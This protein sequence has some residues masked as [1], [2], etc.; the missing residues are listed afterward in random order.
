MYKHTF[1]TAVNGRDPN[2]NWD[3]ESMLAR[4]LALYDDPSR[5]PEQDPADDTAEEDR[6]V[7]LVSYDEDVTS[8]SGTVEIHMVP[9]HL[10]TPSEDQGKVDRWQDET[11]VYLARTN[12]SQPRRTTSRVPEGTRSSTKPPAELSCLPRPRAS[13]TREEA[14]KART[15]PRYAVSPALPSQA[16][17]GPTPSKHVKGR[18]TTRP[19]T[20]WKS[21][22]LEDFRPNYK[23]ATISKE[24]RRDAPQGDSSVSPKKIT[25]IPL[26]HPREPVPHNNSLAGR[27]PN[28][29]GV[30]A[31]CKPSISKHDTPHTRPSCI[32]QRDPS[33]VWNG[34]WYMPADEH[35][36]FLAWANNRKASIKFNNYDPPTPDTSAA[37]L[38][39]MGKLEA[40]CKS[41]KSS[42]F[43]ENS[44]L[45][46]A[47]L[48]NSGEPRYTENNLDS[49]VHQSKYS[50]P[51]QRDMGNECPYFNEDFLKSRTT[52]SSSGEP[53]YEENIRGSD[54]RESNFSSSIQHEMGNE[55]P[56]FEEYPSEPREPLSEARMLRHKESID[57]CRTRQSYY[58]NALQNDNTI[59]SSPHEEGSTDL[60]A[61][62]FSG[63]GSSNKDTITPSRVRKFQY[64][65]SQQD[66]HSM[67]NEPILHSEQLPPTKDIVADPSSRSRIS[68][69]RA[70]PIDLADRLFS[71]LISPKISPRLWI[72]SRFPS[73]KYFSDTAIGS[74]LVSVAELPGSEINKPDQS[75]PV[76]FPVF[77]AVEGLSPENTGIIPRLNI[78]I[79]RILGVEGFRLRMAIDVVV[80][81]TPRILIVDRR[82]MDLQ[83]SIVD[84]YL[85]TSKGAEWRI[86]S[87]GDYALLRSE[88]MSE[89][90]VVKV[91][92][93]WTGKMKGSC[94][95]LPVVVHHV[96]LGG[97]I[98]CET[99]DSM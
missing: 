5:N 15:F 12:K 69:P 9:S 24:R 98:C 81:I 21:S 96:V 6:V 76:Q 57:V 13:Q 27:S 78:E 83:F 82:D 88:K 44:P 66:D 74:R 99:N 58:S 16:N 36:D 87:D 38:E 43:D 59:E 51:Q 34:S 71:G 26:R 18:K 19:K 62:S 10:M 77:E 45:P 67:K 75:C 52:L 64:S 89:G 86:D 40:S 97:E 63:W 30:G 2:V 65:N 56:S 48:S 32:P 22:S 94:L 47:S 39:R 61:R 60:S 28:I 73:S 84:G 50:S 4:L 72:D 29:I 53:R 54:T 55:S 3:E 46:R 1:Q 92:I 37:F 68:S 11:P 80:G 41:N 85:A 17:T 7:H 8:D 20:P 79:F 25:T 93:Y 90:E 42:C 31:L 91:E 70:I 14:V 49:H 33:R 23:T 35:T 95:E